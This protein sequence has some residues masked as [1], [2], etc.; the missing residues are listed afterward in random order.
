MNLVRKTSCNILIKILGL[1]ALLIMLPPQTAQAFVFNVPCQTGEPTALR[2]AIIALNDFPGHDIIRLAA[3]CTYSLSTATGFYNGSTG[4][5]VISDAL[6][7]EGNG[8]RLERAANALHFRLMATASN[9][10]LAITDLTLANGHAVNSSASHPDAGAIYVNGDLSLT[11]VNVINNYAKGEGGG[12]AVFG[13]SHRAIVTNSRFE[14]N[15]GGYGGGL[16]A[17]GPLF[18]TNTS[19]V[20]NQATYVG[21]GV[22]AKGD[23]ASIQSSRFE[24]NSVS[25][26]FALGAGYGG[27]LYTISNLDLV[28]SQFVNNTARWGGGVSLGGSLLSYPGR[29]SI[30]GVHFEANTSLDGAGIVMYNGSVTLAQSVFVAN[31]AAPDGAAGIFL[32]LGQSTKSR[33]INNLWVGNQAGGQG[34][35]IHARA[36]KDT[37]TELEVIHNTL[38]D[39]GDNDDIALKITDV[40]AARTVNNIIANYVTGLAVSNAKATSG[41]NFYQLLNGGGQAEIGQIEPFEGGNNLIGSVQFINPAAG[42]YRLKATS[43]AVNKGFN[44]G[45]NTDLGNTVR[46][47]LN[48]YDPGAYEF[49][50]ALPAPIALADV[51]STPI[52]TVLTIPAPGILGNDNSPTGAPMTVLLSSPPAHGRIKLKVDGSFIYQPNAGFVGQDSFIYLAGTDLSLSS[53]TTVNI[54]VRP[55]SSN[56]TDNRVFLPLIQR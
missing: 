36:T 17:E 2:E 38:A 24:G 21:G 42:N 30:A 16:Y 34:Y 27:G 29:A 8:A 39:P 49:A 26:A 40:S 56:S 4:L 9:V 47:Q 32:R 31:K 19:F 41:Y 33:L 46:P 53:P 55:Q 51:Y 22:S 12:V 28:Q 18:M 37:G 6:T 23:T 43:P 44:L 15:Q 25:D 11:Q 20:N 52:D 5:P 48:G 10:P 7:I 50:P 3:G 35:T 14:N 45:V 1:F 13:K 54:Q